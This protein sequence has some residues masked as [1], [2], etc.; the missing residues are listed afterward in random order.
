M[1]T[2]LFALFN[3]LLVFRTAR[4]SSLLHQIFRLLIRL[5]TVEFFQCIFD[6]SALE[7]F[8]WSDT[9]QLCPMLT[10]LTLEKC[11]GFSV[12]VLKEIVRSRPGWLAES[13][14]RSESRPVALQDLVVDACP[15]MLNE[16]DLRWFGTQPKLRV[17]WNGEVRTTAMSKRT[18]TPILAL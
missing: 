3:L 6:E 16:D 5:T 14:G 11:H 15:A 13:D 12:H 4:I 2:R 1:K 7:G 9:S 10:S 17:R 18:L 8:V